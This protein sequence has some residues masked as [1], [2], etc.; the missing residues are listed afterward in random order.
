[1]SGPLFHQF[2]PYPMD[3]GATAAP[4]GPR[5][6]VSGAPPGMRTSANRSLMAEFA[7]ALVATVVGGLL[8]L[9]G[10]AWQFADNDRHMRREAVEKF[11]DE[12]ALAQVELQYYGELRLP[13]ETLSADDKAAV[14]KQVHGVYGACARLVLVTPE[15]TP[16]AV[17]AR[18][19]L[20]QL[21]KAVNGSYPYARPE[22]NTYVTRFDTSIA[23]F[24][25][26]A[27]RELDL[28]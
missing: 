2:S 17:K 14:M 13:L 12:Y 3:A 20:D 15:L 9:V 21:G 5:A 27:K 11:L 23:D 18:D 25:A 28:P 22:H 1:M 10:V 16:D 4:I 19:V 7:V 26:K 24:L 8:S 6:L